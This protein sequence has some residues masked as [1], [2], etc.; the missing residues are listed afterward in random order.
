[1]HLKL[2][3]WRNSSESNYLLKSENIKRIIQIIANV[4]FFSDNFW[5]KIISIAITFDWFF[6]SSYFCYSLSTDYNE[7]AIITISQRGRP[8]IVSNGYCYARLYGCLD[9]ST[10]WMCTSSFQNKRCKSKIRSKVINGFT[11]VKILT[12][13]HDCKPKLAK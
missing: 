2:N 3:L 13:R 5:W 7:L 9:G 8:Q 12:G 1:M 6:S 11:M 4:L 10:T